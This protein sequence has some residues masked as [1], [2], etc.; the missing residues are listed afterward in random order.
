MRGVIL[1]GGQGTRLRPITRVMNKHMVPILNVPMLHYPLTT[2]RTFGTFSD[3]LII[4]GG[5]HIGSIA[6]YFGD[7]SEYSGMQLT[8]RVQTEAKGIAHA[9]LLAEDFVHGEPFRVILGD[10]VFENSGFL[11][12]LTDADGESAKIY[13]KSV[14]DPQ[15]FGVYDP[16][17]NRIIEKPLHPVSDRAV[18][19][20]YAYPPSV[21]DVIRTLRPSARGELEI[22]DVNNHFLEHGK[23][24]VQDF[25]G[26]W[27]DAGTP[28]SLYRAIR[29]VAAHQ[30]LE[31]S[32]D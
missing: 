18:V 12:V 22:T 29:H 32:T 25:T 3:I 20:F 2:L 31:L 16:K 13:T 6:E 23:C 27:S 17:T 21:F 26:F 28:A 24:L 9:L 15:R 8:Y 30:E 5:E 11:D 10:N 4:S 7:G 14:S 19:G 1:A